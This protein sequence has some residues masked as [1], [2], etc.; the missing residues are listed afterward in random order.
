MLTVVTFVLTEFSKLLTVLRFVLTVVT[1]VLTAF[2]KLLTV[3]TLLLTVKTAPLF[4]IEVSKEASPI[5]LP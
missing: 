3:V 1:F 5:C 2:S 4:G